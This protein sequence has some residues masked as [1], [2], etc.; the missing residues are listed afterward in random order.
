MQID[1][2]DSASVGITSNVRHSPWVMGP[3]RIAARGQMKVSILTRS[4]GRVDSTG[5]RKELGQSL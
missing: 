1:G 5:V 2:S 4:G 3:V